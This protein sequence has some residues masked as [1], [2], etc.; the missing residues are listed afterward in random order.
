MELGSYKHA[1]TWASSLASL[2]VSKA[3]L[4]HPYI[5]MRFFTV[6]AQL[7]ILGSAL[8]HIQS[9]IPTLGTYYATAPSKYPVTFKT[10]TAATDWCVHTFCAGKP[11]AKA[12]D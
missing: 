5:D 12:Y 1:L 7:A 2:S 4:C 8:P 9:I 11:D 10:E 6:I 3:Q